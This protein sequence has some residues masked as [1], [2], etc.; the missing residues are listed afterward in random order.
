MSADEPQTRP[1][2]RTR[3]C[4]CSHPM[5]IG[6][7]LAMQMGHNSGHVTC[8]KCREFLHVER[9]EGDEAWTERWEDF[10]RRNCVGG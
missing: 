8:P 6:M 3:C 5:Q 4:A 7:S 2:L 9:L 10:L 1:R